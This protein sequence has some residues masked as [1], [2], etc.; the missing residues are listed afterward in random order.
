MKKYIIFMLAI[1]F[2]LLTL[3]VA[4]AQEQVEVNTEV[5]GTCHGPTVEAM[6]ES[7]HMDVN[8]AT[9]HQGADQHAENPNEVQPQIDVSAENCRTCHE[10][11]WQSYMAVEK[12]DQQPQK[13]EKFPLL[14]V[15]L[16]GHPFA[17]DYREPRE[18]FNMLE[19]IEL[20]TRGKGA[21]CYSC[22]SADF[23]HQ[24]EDEI[25]YDS[26]V[27]EL[28]SSGVISHPI[29]CV[30]CHDPH[31][32][33]LRTVN[34]FLHDALEEMP[35]D[36]PAQDEGYGN[37]LCGQC[38]V[39][40]NFNLGEENN[41]FPWRKLADMLDY[42]EEVD[43]WQDHGTGG[44]VHPEIDHM[45]Y[46]VQHP[47]TELYWESTH[48]NLGVECVDCHMPKVEDNGQIYTEHWITSPLNNPLDA[49]SDCHTQSADELRETIHTIQENTY[50][51]MQDTMETM[52]TAIDYIEE[53]RLTEGVNDDLLTQ[54][55]DA[56]FVSHL[57]WEWIA[58]ENSMGFHNP[59][60]AEEALQ[61]AKNKAEEATSLAQ[62]AVQEKEDVE[63]TVE[64]ETDRSN[65]LLWV[66][67]AL[68]LGGLAYFV[69]KRR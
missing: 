16:S 27:E 68:V 53:A 10:W 49:C 7:P 59:A 30:N 25:K 1:V 31:K 40:Y 12:V 43:F 42:T 18:H 39:N 69:Y 46:K 61:I 65:A 47:E 5:C 57:N 24:W 51:M 2:C 38:H 54:A 19:D 55:R 29:T 62:R 3:Q 9:C 35:E 21:V 67:A 37:L 44:W 20:T 52:S 60:E 36:H 48:W 45:L 26:D 63:D 11:H 64:E 50:D 23:Y 6:S 58:A 14:P 41:V 15:L 33:E 13:M 28:L 34:V 8:C 66:I 56:Y 4:I 22:K 32:T 17:K